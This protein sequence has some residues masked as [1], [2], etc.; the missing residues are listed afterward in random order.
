[1]NA[2]MN[3]IVKF[4]FACLLVGFCSTLFHPV[5][6][7]PS[8]TDLLPEVN[9]DSLREVSRKAPVVPFNDTIFYIYTRI[10]AYTQEDRAANIERKIQA[11]NN[12]FLFHPDSL[13]IV[14]EEEGNFDISYQENIILTITKNDRKFFN[15][16]EEEIA[17]YYREAMVQ[18]IK[19]YRS[20]TEIWN[21][22]KQAGLVLLIIITLYFLIKY[23]NL[24]FRF[25]SRKAEAMKGTLI[26]GINIKS[27]N[28]LDEEKAVTMILFIIKLFKYFTFILLFYLTIPILFSVFPETRDMA[29]KLMGYITTPLSR[30]WKNIIRNIPNIIT[31]VI[32]VV[33]FRYLLRGIRYF[34]QEIEKGKLKIKGFYP[35]WA[36]PT[37]N[38]VR[39][40]LYVFMFIIIFP[41]LPGAQSKVFQGVSVFLGVIVSLG[42]TSLIGNIVA[43]L[44]LTYMRPFM[45]GDFIKIGDILGTIVEKTPFVTRIRTPKNEDITIPNSNIMSAHTVNYTT[46]TK[47]SGLIVYTSVGV[48]YDVPWRKV[49]ELLIGAAAKTEHIQQKPEPFVLQRALNDFQV[50]YQLNAYTKEEK[51]LSRIY[52]GLHSHIQDAFNEAGIEMTSA[53]YYA[54]RDGSHSTLPEE[55]LPE[56]YRAEGIKVDINDCRKEK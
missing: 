28:V 47:K 24:F 38:I 26:K 4:L 36:I 33:I 42:S 40:L 45:V 9:A 37:Y 29:S 2:Q 50:E 16:T 13:R 34:A 15:Q 39:T 30:I 53:H 21:I 55:Y 3:R 48:S 17:E 56:D 8:V 35:D 52:S 20:K 31:I 25:I 49:H 5:Q 22:L 54:H 27:Y 7:N 18:A 6:A 41:Y 44:V 10:G 19:D 46:S 32:I 23:T 1:M 51:K 12:D 43:G 14:N 11:L